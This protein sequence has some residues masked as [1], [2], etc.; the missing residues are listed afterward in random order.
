V[1]VSFNLH[2]AACHALKIVIPSV[3]AQF[4]VRIDVPEAEEPEGAPVVIMEGDA[5]AV[6]GAFDLLTNTISTK[7]GNRRITH[8]MNVPA[9]KVGMVVG[10]QGSMVKRLQNATGGN[11]NMASRHK[12]RHSKTS[13]DKAGSGKGGR[14]RCGSNADAQDAG[15]DTASDGGD[16]SSVDEHGPQ[17]KKR[18][19]QVPT[20]SNKR[21]GSD[22]ASDSSIMEQGLILTGPTDSVHMLTALITDLLGPDGHMNESRV[23]DALFRAGRPCLTTKAYFSQARYKDAQFVWLQRAGTQSE[24]REQWH[25][26]VEAAARDELGLPPVEDD[27]QVPDTSQEWDVVWLRQQQA[28]AKTDVHIQR[29]ATGRPPVV[30]APAPPAAT[31]ASAKVRAGKSFADILA[32]ESAARRAATA[33]TAAAPIAAAAPAHAGGAAPPAPHNTAAGRSKHVQGSH[34]H[35]DGPGSSKRGGS[36]PHKGGGGKPHKGGGKPGG[37]KEAH[38]MQGA[39]T[40]GRAQATQA[41]GARQQQQTGGGKGGDAASVV[42]SSKHGQKP[43]GSNGPSKHSDSA[44]VSS[45][46]SKGGGRGRGRGRGRGSGSGNGRGRGAP[47]G[48][49]A[50][51]TTSGSATPTQS[52]VPAQTGSGRGR[53]GGRGRGRGGGGRGRGRGRGGG[54]G[55]SQATSQ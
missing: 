36:K 20:P 26:G 49:G 10:K 54:R 42:S 5:N 35:S 1:V 55:V 11:V 29:G 9:D 18:V 44:S 46:N 7:V 22:A 16:L 13:K 24:A 41:T 52:G 39:T 15:F 3:S 47:G 14:I 43:R 31:P 53:G 4:G 21:A 33:S 23:Q 12:N 28:G 8:R 48:V 40:K 27:E 2:H 34:I 17:D 38:K 51:K 30:A 25:A 45:G 37:P 6:A 50:H 32:E 19:L